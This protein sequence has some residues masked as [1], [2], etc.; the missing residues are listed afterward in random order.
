V[1]YFSHLWVVGRD[2]QVPAPVAL[3]VV[4][5]DVLAMAGLRADHTRLPPQVLAGREAHHRGDHL[6]HHHPAFLGLVR[7]LRRALDDAGLGS[8]P[9]HAVLLDGTLTLAGTLKLAGTADQRGDPATPVGDP[10]VEAFTGA[11]ALGDLV[12]PA[13][14]AADR[15][16]FDGVLRR[17]AQDRPER[18]ADPGAVAERLFRVV[19]R[20]P[21]LAFGPEQTATVARVLAEHRPALV[22]AGADLLADVAA[23]LAP[24]SDGPDDRY[25][26][27]RDQDD[28]Y[29]GAM[30]GP[31]AVQPHG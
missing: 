17:T 27:D 24:G 9:A 7:R 29:P 15:S 2:R 10:L 20:R 3:G 12:H 14:A 4:L 5:P 28:R 22:A 13:L 23:G 6:F 26:D 30:A 8:G 31:R 21:R 11:L 16:R 18:L 19:G 1:N 25:Q